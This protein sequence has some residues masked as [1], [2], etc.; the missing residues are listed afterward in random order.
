M[1]PVKVT[2]EG[3]AADL[4][5]ANGEY[6]V[7]AEYGLSDR[8]Q[9]VDFFARVQPLDLP[10]GTEGCP[11]AVT[12]EAG[13]KVYRFQMLQG[14]IY[15]EETETYVT[16]E[17]IHDL[18]ALP[19][20]SGEVR[21]H[22]KRAAGSNPQ[23]VRFPDLPPTKKDLFEWDSGRHQPQVTFDVFRTGSGKWGPIVVGGL[24][25]F[26]LPI[27]ILGFTD[28]E[29][30]IGLGTGAT[31]AALL[32]WA[33]IWMKTRRRF[34]TVGFDWGNNIMWGRWGRNASALPEI[35]QHSGYVP[36]ANLIAELLLDQS[37]ETFVFTDEDGFADEGIQRVWQLKA[38]HVTGKTFDLGP[39][40]YTKKDAETALARAS[41][42]LAGQR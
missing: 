23:A 20:M 31:A 41:A 27:A 22:R 13:G 8:Q 35:R 38:R 40:L 42:L 3:I 26:F 36:D 16:P 30:G 37:T 15:S 5:H 29:V 25:L 19:A 4:T 6:G 24:G 17:Q 18:V 7:Q 39:T 33:R 10:E 21:K 34:F 28:G 9:L 11:P 12:L 14:T 2:L 32:T 1:Y